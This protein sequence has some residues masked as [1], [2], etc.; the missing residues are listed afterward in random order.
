MRQT[1]CS[2]ATCSTRRR[3]LQ[4]GSA[5]WQKTRARIGVPVPLPAIAPD[6]LVQCSTFMCDEVPRKRAEALGCGH[7]FCDAC[8]EGFLRSEVNKGRDCIYSTCMGL[9]CKSKSCKHEPQDNCKCQSLIPSSFFHRWLPSDQR[10]LYAKWMRKAFID[11]NK[12]LCWCPANGCELVVEYVRDDPTREIQCKCG[13]CFCFKCGLDAHL[14]VPCDLARR[15]LSLDSSDALT[16]KLIASISKPCPKCQVPIQKNEACI[17]MTCGVCKHGFCWLCKEPWASHGGS[18]YACTKYNEQKEM[19]ILSDEQQRIISNTKELQKYNLYRESYN[20]HRK[21]VEANTKFIT[22]M[23]NSKA[24]DADKAKFLIDA[25]M[26][27]VAGHRLLQWSY[28]LSYFLKESKEKKLYLYQQEQLQALAKELHDFLELSSV[29]DMCDKRDFV[30]SR[31]RTVEKYRKSTLDALENGQLIEVI[32]SNADTSNEA[33][34]CTKCKHV[35]Q[36]KDAKECGKC[37][38]C[39][40]HGE[41]QCWGCTPAKPR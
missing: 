14:P 40:L 15:F 5:T 41:T 22:R 34:A 36:D 38:A 29:E 27:L 13:H 28:C 6:Q 4:T 25:G 11:K 19:G 18:Y 7:W 10:P 39:R 26:M 31:A 35:M 16:A 37:R 21:S 24:I 2:E 17:H 9:N 8:W 1:V 33:W 3:Q 32:L 12:Q 20:K 23:E 30:V